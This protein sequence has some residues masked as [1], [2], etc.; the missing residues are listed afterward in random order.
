MSPI[1]KK[2][3]SLPYIVI[4]ATV[5]AIITFSITHFIGSKKEADLLEK[6][7]VNNACSYSIKRMDGYKFVKP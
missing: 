6:A 5:T 4:I 3:L 1:L 7:A 2:K